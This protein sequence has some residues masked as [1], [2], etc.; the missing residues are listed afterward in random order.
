MKFNNQHNAGNYI[1]HTLYGENIGLPAYF[2]NI[3]NSL[4][5]NMT[6]YYRFGLKN[7]SN[8]QI[9]NIKIE[10]G[11]NDKVLAVI[12]AKLSVDEDEFDLLTNNIFIH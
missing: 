4:Q 12:Y 8:I 7:G 9:R 3:V 5:E 2:P 6:I 10:Y 1:T 11:N